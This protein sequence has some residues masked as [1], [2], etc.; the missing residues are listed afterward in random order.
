[1]KTMKIE[2]I[3]CA[4]CEARIKAAL[5]SVAGVKSAEVSHEAGTAKV[6]LGDAVDDNALT[7]AVENAG[8]KVLGIE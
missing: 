5:E 4:H 7:C 2:G 8:Y 3:M 1:M 6:T